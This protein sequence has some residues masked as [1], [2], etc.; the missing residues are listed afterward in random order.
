VINP[1]L[2]PGWD[3]PHDISIAHGFGRDWIQSLRSAL[4]VVPSVVTAGRD[5]NVI[6]NPDHPDSARIS[7]GPETVVALDPRFFGP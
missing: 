2:L 1:A 3:D 6:V 7:V 4:L 5:T